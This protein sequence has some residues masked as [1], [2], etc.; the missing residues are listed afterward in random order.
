M[1]AAECRTFLFSLFPSVFDFPRE[2]T[3]TVSWV[4]FEEW[5]ILGFQAMTFGCISIL[6]QFVEARQG[7][8]TW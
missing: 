5:L 1:Q 3:W 8:M 7:I 4:W 6:G 2:D